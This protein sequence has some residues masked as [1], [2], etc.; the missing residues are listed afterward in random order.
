MSNSLSRYVAQLRSLIGGTFRTVRHRRSDFRTEAMESRILLSAGDLVG[1]VFPFSQNGQPNSSE[2]SSVAASDQYFVSGKPSADVGGFDSTGAVEIY[3]AV[4]GNHLFT[5]N[6]P[7]SADSDQFGNSVAVSGNRVV[8]GAF[9]DDTGARDAGSVYVFDLSGGVATLAATINNP[10]PDAD[11]YFG[12]SV[13]ISGD[14]LVVGASGDNS[15]ANYSGSAYLFDLSAGLPVLAAS[16]GNPAPA[17]QD[18]F[19]S[20]VAID[21]N[22]V[23]IGAPSDDAGATNAGSVYLYDVSSGSATLTRTVNN[24]TPVSGDSFG[25]AIAV[26]GN[27]MVIGAS[28]DDT[29]ASNAGSAYLYTLAGGTATLAATI[30]NPGPAADDRFGQAVS[31]D[32]NT[33]VVGAYTDDTGASNAGSAYVYNLIG[34]SAQLLATINNPVPSTNDSRC[35]S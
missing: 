24:P 33:V 27:R 6:N 35:S 15:G 16:I 19:G 21:G 11:D 26:R 25:N 9:S 34:N 12:I 10:Y 7:T 32:G 17:L 20:T 13:A 28:S 18:R 22:T 29:G 4:N 31:I 1:T 30:N 3:D 14:K 23:V 8:V 2:G 5:L